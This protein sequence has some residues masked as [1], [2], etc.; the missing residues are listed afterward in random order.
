LLSR[1]TTSLLLL[2]T[3]GLTAC[4]SPAPAD[5][6][7]TRTHGYVEGAVEAT[8]PQLT[9]ATVDGT[10]SLGLLDLIEGSSSTIADVE[11]VTSVSTD[12]RYVFASAAARGELTIVDTG[13]WAIDHEDHAH[14]YRAE[15]ALIGTVEGEGEAVV[16][17]GGAV[18]VVAFTGSGEGILLDREALDDGGVDEVARIDGELFVP[19]GDVV[20]AASG[21][22]I[23]AY[24]STGDTLDG[25]APCA[26]P[27][28]T[29]TTRVGVVFGCADGAVLVTGGAGALE[30]ESIPY[31]DAVA[32]DDRATEF[33]ARPGRPTVAAVAGSTGAWLLDTRE[34]SWSR[35]VTEA[36]L[37]RVSAAD[38]RDGNVVA[39]AADGRVLVLD[40]ATGATLA[41][42][43]PLL[44]ATAADAAL[45][46]G[47]ELA[48]DANRAYVN[49]PAEG[50]VFEIDYADG[51][52]VAREFPAPTA[53]LFLVQTGGLS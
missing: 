13:V 37:L 17:G 22:D 4:A 18:T 50:T 44:A 24:D 26:S 40:P 30:F 52:R 31:P 48:V 34:R 23:V 41:A 15:P 3:L 53:P 14:Y 19:V 49:A 35:L 11:G 33:R 27:A 32:A 42:T 2:A 28:G 51:A 8:E 10:G 9:L 1:N 36:P 20:L 47:V 6:G 39:V 5:D 16:S 43:P 46:E 45:L 12:G 29:I 7:E 21:D 25:G 38:D